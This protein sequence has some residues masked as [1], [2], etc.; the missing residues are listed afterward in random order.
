MPDAGR[1]YAHA[2]LGMVLTGAVTGG[3]ANFCTSL[4]IEY[5][6]PA[7]FKRAYGVIYPIHQ[8]PGSMG[9]L[10]IVQIAA[11]FGGYTVAYGAMAAAM[12]LAMVVFMICT[13]KGGIFVKKAEEK[14]GI[15][16]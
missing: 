2:V 5:W 16:K 3:A 15:A 9:T 14:W 7:N 1:Q 13:S 11:R 6:G 12:V 8:I 10:F 4:V